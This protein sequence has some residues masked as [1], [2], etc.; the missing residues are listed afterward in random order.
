MDSLDRHEDLS[1][2]Q[3]VAARAGVCPGSP[4]SWKRTLSVLSQ[5]LS[6]L[7]LIMLHVGTANSGGFG[8]VSFRGKLI[9]TVGTIVA[10]FPMLLLRGVSRYA[11]GVPFLLAAVWTLWL[12]WKS[13]GWL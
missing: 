9:I 2:S 4:F 3:H 11:V 10:I 5:V 1:Q 7:W 8:H 13:W 12:C 6:V